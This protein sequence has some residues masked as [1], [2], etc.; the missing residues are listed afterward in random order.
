MYTIYTDSAKPMTAATLEAAK[1]IANGAVNY[2]Q[3]ADTWNE[4]DMPGSE[5]NRWVLRREVGVGNGETQFETIA[6]VVPQ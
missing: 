5:R 6:E 4:E 2:A 3:A 1:E